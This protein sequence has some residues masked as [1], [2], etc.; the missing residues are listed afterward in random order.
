MVTKG[1]SLQDVGEDLVRTILINTE[2]ASARL[3]SI[4]L[5]RDG[6]ILRW[7]AEL[8]RDDDPDDWS[9]EDDTGTSFE[10]V[11][12]SASAR[13]RHRARGESRYIPALPSHARSLLVRHEMY[14][15]YDVAVTAE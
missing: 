2:L 5:F 13:D 12:G 8:E 4:D 7:A 10:F 3:I 6:L 15:T 9:L 1:L 14:G 11:G